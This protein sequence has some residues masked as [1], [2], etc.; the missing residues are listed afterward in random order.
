MNV[1]L[2]FSTAA[3]S[4]PTAAMAVV[5]YGTW[6]RG[7][8]VNATA[9]TAHRITA[10]GKHGPVFRGRQWSSTIQQPTPGSAQMQRSGIS[11]RCSSPT[12]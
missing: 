4:G 10:S 3:P 1:L 6:P 9:W 8:R 5:P 2:R 7:Y 12:V 11:G